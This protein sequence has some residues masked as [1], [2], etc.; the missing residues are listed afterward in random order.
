MG[1]WLW[2]A[3]GVWFYRNNGTWP[4]ALLLWT[5]SLLSSDAAVMCL[6]YRSCLLGRHS[7][8]LR[9]RKLNK[10]WINSTEDDLK[11]AGCCFVPSPNCGVDSGSSDLQ[12]SL[13]SFP[14]HLIP[15]VLRDLPIA[16]HHTRSL[17][18]WLS[19]SSSFKNHDLINL[20]IDLWTS[21][22]SLRPDF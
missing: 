9:D 8:F 2:A 14:F 3:S 16:T 15:W 1:S 22:P 17:K 11:L 19:S 13:S 6:L 7:Y 18:P 20:T 12:A 5:C 10:L 4:W 21:A